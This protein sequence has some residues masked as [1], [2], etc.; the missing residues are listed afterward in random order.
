M[1]TGCKLPAYARILTLQIS[2]QKLRNEPQPTA[3]SDARI[4]KVFL[5]KVNDLFLT[6]DAPPSLASSTTPEWREQAES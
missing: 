3:L 1:P 2:C 4:L 6:C 5:V